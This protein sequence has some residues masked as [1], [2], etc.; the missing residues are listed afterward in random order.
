M[1][2][3]NGDLI[4]AETDGGFGNTY[5]DFIQIAP[6]PEPRSTWLAAFGFLAVVCFH[7]RHPRRSLP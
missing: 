2:Y 1:S 3:L 5:T 7:R 4:V 6:I